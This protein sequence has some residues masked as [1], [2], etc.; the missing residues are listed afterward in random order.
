MPASL[1]M[2]NRDIAVNKR[3][4]LVG[5]FFF[6]LVLGCQTMAQAAHEGDPDPSFNGGQVR[7]VSIPHVAA[8]NDYPVLIGFSPVSNG[9]LAAIRIGTLPSYTVRLVK[10]LANG[11]LLRISASMACAILTTQ[12]SIGV[13]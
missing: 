8:S 13:R 9:Y 6:A 4:Q 11:T 10:V 1:S 7:V 5:L 3:N 12:K 2:A